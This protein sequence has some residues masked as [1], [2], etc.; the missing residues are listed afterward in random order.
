VDPVAIDFERYFH[1]GLTRVPEFILSPRE[2]DFPRAVAPNQYHIGPSVELDREEAACDYRFNSAFGRLVRAR[3]KGTPLVYCSL[4]TAAWRYAGAEKFIAR[5]VAAA[6]GATWNLLLATGTELELP[7]S[8]SR[9]ENVE[10][11]QVVPQLQVLRNCDAMITHGGMNSITECLL[12]GV[13]M[14]VCPGTTQIDQGGNAAR[15]AFH[16]LGLTGGMKQASAAWIRRQ[17]DRILHEPAY[18]RRV[19]AMGRRI[20][21]SRA[22]ADGAGILLDTVRRHYPGLDKGRPRPR[23]SGTMDGAH[24]VPGAQAGVVEIKAPAGTSA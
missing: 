14:A 4:G 20:R 12:T 18:R 5:V 23:D 11:F 9:P 22:Y 10:I 24:P 1:L 15:V 6:R 7:P 2:F 21:D 8:R 17:L 19:E 16:Q 3:K 13:P